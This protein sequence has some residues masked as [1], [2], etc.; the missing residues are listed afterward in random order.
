[1]QAYARGLWRHTWQQALL[2]HTHTHTP[3][4]VW[5]EDRS[6]VCDG[7]S[8]LDTRILISNIALKFSCCMRKR[9]WKIHL[10][11]TFFCEVWFNI[12]SLFLLKKYTRLHF[13]VAKTN[14]SDPSS[15][16][17]AAQAQTWVLLLETSL[18]CTVSHFG[19]KHLLVRG[20]HFFSNLAALA[21]F[22]KFSQ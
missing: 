18:Y 8:D 16:P 15:N 17:L 11:W 7:G 14:S 4:W 9:L 6:A 20:Q 13:P 22:F 2:G 19:S 10:L 3:H 12:S 21:Q 5:Q 1:M